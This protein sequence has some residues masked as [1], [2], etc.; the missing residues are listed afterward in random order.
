MD[1][2]IDLLETLLSYKDEYEWI[3][4][5]ENWF[6]KDEI[7]EDISA[8]ANGAA[9]CGKEFG[10]IVWGVNDATKEVVG[11]TV[12]FNK[13]IDNEPYKHYLARNL[14]PKISFETVEFKYNEARIVML[15]I[16]QSKS[17]VTKFKNEAFIRIESSKEKLSK[18]PEWE[19]KLNNTLVN[20]YPT[21]VNVAAPDYAQELTFEKLFMYYGAKGLTLRH[22]TFEKTLKL[23][24]KDNKYNIMAYILSDQNEIPIRVS[25]FSGIDKSAPLYS[26]KEFGN[27]CI[28]YSM[29]KILEY[30]DAIN[31]IQADERNRIS[32][33]ID[34]PLFDYE[35]YH[36]AIL[37]AFIHNKWLTLNGPQISI[38]TDRIEILSHGGL[39]LDQDIEG[40]YSGAS[41]PVNEILASIFLQLR[42]SERSGRGVPKIVSKYGKDSIKIEK[43]R[44]IVT[45]P[46]NKINVN[47]FEITSSN[48]SKK[49][50]KSQET[51]IKLIRNNPNI[52]IPQ[53]MIETNLAA[54]SVKKNLKILK[55]YKIVERVGSN[56]GG[57]WKINE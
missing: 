20:G 21:I 6:S 22:D 42:I 2:Y 4:F 56:N 37:N 53:I 34:V 24:N 31:I 15:I 10:Y 41:I 25:I 13:D 52:T 8:I 51:I 43:N 45:I 29:D 40:F 3:D 57:Y 5:K 39:A 33:R 48:T 54:V 32:E 11:T 19:I 26:V 50:N 12:N 1:K 47:S 55:D 46:F 23:K 44:I 35:A 9:L 14:T 49:L 38:F 17:I 7:G 27:T 16:P 36:E 28:L 18:Y 30:G